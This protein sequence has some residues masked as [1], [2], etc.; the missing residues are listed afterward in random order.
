MVDNRVNAE[1]ADDGAADEGPGAR[2][3]RAA[4]DLD[5]ARERVEDLARDGAAVEGLGEDPRDVAAPA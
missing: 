4:L 5:D 3:E 2:L 1:V